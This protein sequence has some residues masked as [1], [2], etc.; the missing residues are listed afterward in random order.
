MDNTKT[1]KTTVFYPDGSNRDEEA[2]IIC[3]HDLTVIVNERPVYRLICTKNNLREL[4]TGRLLTDGLIESAGDIYKLYFSKCE[5]EASIFLNKDI[6]W[7]DDINTVSTCCSGNRAYIKR[8]RE[9][10][11][12]HIPAHEFQMEWVFSLAEEFGKTTGLHAITGGS[13][14]CI[15]AR[16]GETVFTC[17]DIGRHNAVDKAVGY[18]LLN[19]IPLPE[20]MIFTSGRVPVDMVEKVIT[21][22]IPVLVSKSVPT[23]E[24]VELAQ[25]YGLDL[26][27][28]AWPDKCEAF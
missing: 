28:R 21:A 17:E 12:K 19:G 6:S 8:K 25:E 1:L 4:V 7:E 13:H 18:A 24:S 26:I 2:C 11:L 9:G 5:K 14:I 20:C 22:G 23:F 27:C 10:F 15:L 16:K 3:E